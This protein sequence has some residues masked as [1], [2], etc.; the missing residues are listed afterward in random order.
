[1]VK[2]QSIYMRE[3]RKNNPEFM[4]KYLAR[5]KEN[6]RNNPEIR[7]KQAIRRKERKYG[8]SHEDWLRMYETQDGKCLICGKSFIK[9]SD[10]KVDHNHRTGKIRGLLC[11]NCNLG[12]GFLNDDPKIMIKAIEYLLGEK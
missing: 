4:K 3:R 11:N 6:K 9:P 10:A 7:E 2:E 8:L 5:R 1:M 12:I